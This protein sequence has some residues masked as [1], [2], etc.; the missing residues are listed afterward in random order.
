MWYIVST[1]KTVEIEFG[2]GGHWLRQVWREGDVAIYERSLSREHS[3]HE[4]ELVIV[5]IR[6]KRVMPNGVVVD[7]GEAYPSSSEWGKFAW[8]FPIRERDWVLQLA[9]TLSQ[10]KK[11]RATL[12]REA[13]TASRRLHAALRTVNTLG[14]VSAME[15]CP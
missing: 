9:R 7:A 6:P 8:S 5:R 12:V 3:V 4:L 13:V 15:A 10:C 14:L 2:S 1:V 11:E